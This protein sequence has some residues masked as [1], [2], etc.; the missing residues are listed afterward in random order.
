MRKRSGGRNRI[1]TEPTT[2]TGLLLD[3][4]SFDAYTW[5]CFLSNAQPLLFRMLP[6]GDVISLLS[7]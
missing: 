1:T 4:E 6:D 5:L 2:E 3:F 7:S